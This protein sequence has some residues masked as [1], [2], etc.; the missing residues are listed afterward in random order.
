MDEFDV[1]PISHNGRVYNVITAMDL[2]FREVRGLIDALVAL[3]AFAA[4]A[5]AQEPGNLF[6]CA[7]EGID[8]EVDVQG[9][10]VAVYRREPAK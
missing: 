4:G 7:V 10:D 6:T 9:F 3:G 5:D 1:Y 2:T 8:F